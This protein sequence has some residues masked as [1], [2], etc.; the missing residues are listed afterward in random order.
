M[1]TNEIVKLTREAIAELLRSRE[2]PDNQFQ[3][4]ERRR[5]PRWPFPGTVELRRPDEN[6][7]ALWFAT[8]RD[9]GATGVGMTTDHYFK[10][11]TRLDVAL[12]LPEASFY[13]KATVRYCVEVEDETQD[14]YAMGLEF[15]F[16]A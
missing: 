14:Q 7:P 10:P 1:K 12:H 11:G 3:G 9:V 8:C 16:D 15:D 2:A 13:G 5:A 6:D 4:A